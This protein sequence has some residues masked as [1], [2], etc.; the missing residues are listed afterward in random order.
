[1]SLWV[2]NERN[3]ACRAGITTMQLSGNTIN[4]VCWYCDFSKE[5]VILN[6]LI[7]FITVFYTSMKMNQLKMWTVFVKSKFVDHLL[8]A[9]IKILY[10]ILHHFLITSLHKMLTIRRYSNSCVLWHWYCRP[11]MCVYIVTV[12]GFSA[13]GKYFYTW[14]MKE[15]V[16]ELGWY[17][18]YEDTIHLLQRRLAVQCGCAILP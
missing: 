10:K 18:M 5:P 16:S 2:S 6:N 11:V 3:R 14:N 12:N 7:N 9:I 15:F 4:E 8:G 13:F 1:M 17:L